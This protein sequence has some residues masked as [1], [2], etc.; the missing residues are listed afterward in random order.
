MQ[1]VT[2]HKSK[3]I[4]YP[5]V[6]LP[7]IWSSRKTTDKGIIKFH[8]EH[9]HLLHVDLGSEQRE[10]SIRL[11]ERERLAED[12]RLLY[13]ALTRAQQRCYFSW[14]LFNGAADSAMAWLLHQSESAAGSPECIMEQLDNEKI[15][16]ALLSL[17]ETSGFEG[18]SNT[19]V[20]LLVTELPD[21]AVSF[22]QSEDTAEPPQALQ[23]TGKVEQSW[24]LTSFSGLSSHL[25]HDY[26]IDL[27]DFDSLDMPAVAE[28]VQDATPSR[29]TFPR[30][31]RAGECLHTILEELDFPRADPEQLDAVVE[32]KLDQF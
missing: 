3:G 23:F 32:R 6:F 4:E 28:Q 19:G 18:N 17:N 7:Y 8:D 5:L 27:P 24:Q 11:A 15:K 12:L 20:R 16:S 10:E 1:I 26:R 25:K 22:K 31:A 21:D 29:F 30:G 13:V 14:G 2:I 9:K